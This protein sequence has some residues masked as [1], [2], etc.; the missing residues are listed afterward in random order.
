MQS[1]R[2]K[3]ND[4]VQFVLAVAVAI[5][6]NDPIFPT[7]TAPINDAPIPSDG[8]VKFI[9]VAVCLV[10][11]L[12]FAPLVIDCKNQFDIGRVPCV[13]YP[14]VVSVTLSVVDGIVA[15]I[16]TFPVP[17]VGEIVTLFPAM[18]CETPPVA[19]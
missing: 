19:V 2:I 11:K 14:F 1:G 7:R 9:D 17:P 16:V 6:L 18:I 15:L 13:I 8:F 5:P 4:I 3:N 10:S 12:K